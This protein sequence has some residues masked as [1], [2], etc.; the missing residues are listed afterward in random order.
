MKTRQDLRRIA[1]LTVAGV[2]AT[3]AVARSRL[4]SRPVAAVL[5]E[6]AHLGTGA[7]VLGAWKRPP[8]PPF[9]GALLA[10]SVLL[11]VDHVPD[12]LGIRL[13]RPRGMRPRTH[14]VATL[15]ALATSPRL[16]GALVGVAAHLARDL[17]TG[18]NAVPLLWPFSKRP[19]E[20]PYGVYAAGLAA[21]AGV[22][23]AQSRIRLGASIPRVAPRKSTTAGEVAS[24]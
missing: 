3:D 1:L 10:G 18:T 22:A 19:F 8:E 13:L 4:W 17:A 16:D 9:A 14:S 6:A 5:D 21:L 15:L 20:L 12:V 11:D 7:L 24:T 23:V 2:L